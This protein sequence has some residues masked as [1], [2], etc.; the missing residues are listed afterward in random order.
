LNEIES[1]GSSAEEPDVP[2]AEPPGLN[3]RLAHELMTQARRTGVSLVGPDGLLAGVTRTV[4]QTALD[5]EM[6]EHLG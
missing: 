4:L 5:T 6:T 2:A 3:V 1:A